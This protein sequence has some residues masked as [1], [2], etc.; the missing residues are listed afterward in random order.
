MH[1]TD[2]HG[3]N[4]IFFSASPTQRGK[5]NPSACRNGLYSLVRGIVAGVVL[6]FINKGA[7]HAVFDDGLAG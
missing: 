1:L 7:R 6:A 5:K 2:I 3:K 4:S